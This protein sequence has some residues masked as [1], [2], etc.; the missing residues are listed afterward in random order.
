M[1]EIK[2]P[3]TPDNREPDN[4]IKSRHDGTTYTIREFM[5]GK[6]SALDIVTRRVKKELDPNL[7]MG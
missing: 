1:S 7:S 3:D 4:V 2:K 6:E 5:D